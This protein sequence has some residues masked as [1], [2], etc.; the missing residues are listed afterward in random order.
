MIGQ[1][2]THY[3]IVGKLGRGGMGEVFLAEDTSL[4]RKVA[5]KFLP[6][7][8]QQDESAH[9]RFLREA[10]S[11]AALEHPNICTIHEVSAAD[12]KDFIVMEY[13]EGQTLR[14]RLAKGPL[15]LV[16]SLQIVSDVAEALEEAH[17]KG[18]IHRDLKPANVMLTRKGHAKVMDFGLAKRL[19]PLDGPDSRAETLTLMPQESSP[20]GTLAYMSPEQLRCETVDARSDIF[21]LGVVFYEMLG[22]QHPFRAG[23]IL[24]TSDRILH[25]TPMPV[26]TLNRNVPPGIERLLDSMLAKN[27]AERPGS[28]QVLLTDLQSA[29]HSEFDIRW[30]FARILRLWK[31]RRGVLLAVAGILLLLLVAGVPALRK[32]IRPDLNAKVPAQ[33]HLAILPFAAVNVTDEVAA[34][35]KGLTETLNARLTRIT[36]RHSLQV[37]PASEVRAQK[38]HTAEQARREFGVNL[39]LEGSLQRA[40]N[41]L[42]VTYALVDVSA[43]R[44]LRADAITAAAHD[45]FALEDLVVASVLDNLEVELQPG[46]KNTLAAQGTMQPSA[47][48]F[49]LQARGYLQDYD[50]P[51]SI[52][53]AIEVLQRALEKDPQYALAYAGLGEARWRQYQQTKDTKWVEEA[54]HA[55]EKA[56]ALDAGLAS[57]HACLG[58]VFTGTGKYEQAMH[59]FQR[60]VSLDPTSDDAHRG[61]ASAYQKLGRLPEA[62]RTYQRAISLRPQYW[63]GYNWLGSFYYR[64][65]RYREAAEE[66]KQVIRLA[67]DSFTGYSNLGGT[68]LQ[69]GHYAEAITILQRSVA[70]RP[71]SFACSNL[72]TAYFF[73]RKFSESASAYEKAATLD[74]RDWQV[75]GNLGDS[76]CFTSGKRAQADEAYRKALSLGEIGLQ[77]NAR[78]ARLLGYMSYYHAMLNEKAKAQTFERQALAVAPRDPELLFNL[79]L[80]HS[81][82]GETGQAL[83]WLEKALAAGYSRATV[84]DTPLLDSLRNTR[85]FQ[86]LLQEN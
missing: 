36:E 61:L 1:T 19:V 82:L 45:P 66:F 37:V 67:P 38:V 71:T 9:N 13:V 55:C 18:I 47:Y 39:V 84:R 2:V 56:V 54:L 49:Y 79:A 57:G 25:D 51:E 73:Q 34:F 48:D 29:S 14:D 23:S 3:K 53:S 28:A 21:S 15:P 35:S 26:R 10:R 22:R 16:E 81:Q 46:E 68:Y 40:G 75:W 42:R 64:Q 69:D 60:A 65:G 62:E 52:V 74:D 31:R 43:H 86:K 59:E 58:V 78:D 24:A 44:Q 50:K 77:V 12:G 17:G 7:E 6:P 80:T 83:D 11:A 41:L 33:M 5:L 72:A 70:L 76:Y 30:M 27:P 63:A 20:V 32:A 8:M 4:R 85:G